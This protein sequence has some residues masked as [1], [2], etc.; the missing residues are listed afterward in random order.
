[1][2]GG[3]GPPVT[4]AKGDADA[5]FWPPQEPAHIWHTLTETHVHTFKK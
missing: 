3:S 4:A 2:L 5:L 1:M